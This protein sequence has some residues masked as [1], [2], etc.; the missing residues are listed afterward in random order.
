[1]WFDSERCKR[2]IDGLST[3]RREYDETNKVFK[4]SPVKDWATH[5]A[6]A[7]QTLALSYGTRHKFGKLE[8]A[9]A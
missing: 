5:P 2:G 7:F 9:V 1:V 8:R 3:Y 6:D 4:G